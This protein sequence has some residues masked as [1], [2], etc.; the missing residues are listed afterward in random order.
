[1]AAPARTG[2]IENLK[3][4]RV[5][6]E[7]VTRFRLLR[8]DPLE[9]HYPPAARQAGLDG[10]ASVDVLINE[11]GQVLE[12]QVISESPQGKGFGLAALDAAKT[13]EFEN[14]LRRWVVFTLNIE[15]LP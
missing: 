12:A 3:A 1:M 5:Q 4:L 6:G 13:F 10:F 15:F 7:Q 2:R 8:G 14:P 9:R 11:A